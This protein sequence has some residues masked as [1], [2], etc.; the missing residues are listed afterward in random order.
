MDASVSY[1]SV[2]ASRGKYLRAEPIAAL[3]DRGMVH[4]VGSY[5]K[6]ED[7]MCL[8]LPGDKSPNRMDAL[9]WCF[10]ELMTVKKPSFRM[11]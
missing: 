7:E 8:W 2:T 4:H 6:L 10:T 9:V 5:S 3:Y 11:I 1:K